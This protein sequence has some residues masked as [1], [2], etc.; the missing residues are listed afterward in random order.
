MALP[1]PADSFDAVVNVESSHCYG[2]FEAFLREVNRVLKPG[3]HFLYADFRDQAKLDSWREQLRGSGM[4]LL[5]KANITPNVLAAL[6][7]DD[8][9][10]LALMEKLIPKQI[11][12]SF[13]DFA[14]VKGSLVY[15]EFRSGGMQYFQFLLQKE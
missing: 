1:F 2:S 6:D 4:K 10:K 7:A 11:L 14:A 13:K 5:L 15:E 12:G 8:E 9:R 3:G